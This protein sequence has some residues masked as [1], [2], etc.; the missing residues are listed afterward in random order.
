MAGSRGNI[1]GEKEKK[2]VDDTTDVTDRK[3]KREN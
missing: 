2:K 1:T 3:Q